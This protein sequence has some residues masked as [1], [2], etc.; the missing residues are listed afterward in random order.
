[1]CRE[2]C[3]ECPYKI[4]SKHNESFKG[5]VGVVEKYGKIKDGIHACHMITSDVWGYKGDITDDNVCIGSKN[6]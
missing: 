6:R 1:M 4:K 5:Y 2:S 3:M